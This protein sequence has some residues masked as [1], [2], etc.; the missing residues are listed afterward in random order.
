MASHVTVPDGFVVAIPDTLG[1]AE[2]ATLP[3]AAATALHGLREL[4]RLQPGETVLLHGAAGGVGLAALQIA[5]A[6]GARVLAT[7]GSPEKRALLTLLGAEAVFDSRS[8]AFAEGVMAA[9]GGRGVDVALNSLSGEAMR[10]TLDCVAPFGRFIELGK[11]DFYANTRVGLRPLRRNVGYFGVDLDALLAARPDAAAPL[12]QAL[13]TALEAGELAPLPHRVMP[14]ASVVEAFRLMQRSGHIG[15]I[16]LTPP[17]ASAG[18][19]TPAALLARPDRSWLIAGGTGGFGLALAERLAERGAG[20]IWLTGRRGQVAEAEAGRLARIRARGTRVEVVACDVADEAAMRALIAR[21]NVEGPR[22]GGVAHTAMVL[23]DAL[24]ADVD[25]ARLAAT[26][27]PKLAGAVLLDRLTRDAQVEHCLLFSSVAALFG[28]PG[29]SA[30]VAANAAVEAVA[31]GRLAAGLPALAVQW[32]PIADTGVLAA[33][34]AM[35]V[36]LEARGAGLMTAAQALDALET[37]LAGRRPDDAVLCL[38]PMRWGRLAP[39]L[40]LLSTPLFERLAMEGTP[41][42]AAAQA[43]LRAALAGLDDAAALRRLV[44]LFRAEAAAI[45]RLDPAEIDPVR[46]MAELGFDSLMAVELKL[47]AEE[48]HGIML[49]VFALAEGATIA[50]L[51]ARVLADLRRGDGAADTDDEAEAFIARHAAVGQGA[52]AAHLRD[53]GYAP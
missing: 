2:A 19:K 26:V 34:D 17:A 24:F 9:T 16:V 40:P 49:P 25:T 31:R 15:K 47:S 51:A 5:R 27:R 22:L 14:G 43:D 37:A 32:G 45:L 33:D 44:E 4:G 7:A 21:I 28:N 50:A 30:Y 36:R 6:R 1:F 3:V 10:R 12:L 23:D 41:D 18:A 48:R 46:P 35:R 29:Q 39:D 8:L 52:L 38:A 20:A 53:K 13:S 42:H 11:R